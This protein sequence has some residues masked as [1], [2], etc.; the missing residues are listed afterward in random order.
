M[1]FEL[2]LQKPDPRRALA[3]ALTIA[4]SYAAGGFIPL[5]PYFSLAAVSTSLTIS[6]AVT[7]ATLALSRT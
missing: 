4:S 7:L 5:S 3:S 2:G 1:R 6:I